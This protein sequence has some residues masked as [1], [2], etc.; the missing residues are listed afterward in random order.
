MLYLVLGLS[1][2]ALCPVVNQLH[3][4]EQTRA[5]LIFTYNLLCGL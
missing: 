3:V 1:P 5:P 4:V 2:L